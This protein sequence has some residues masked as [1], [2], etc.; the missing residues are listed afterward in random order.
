[1]ADQEELARDHE[2]RRSL[3]QGTSPDWTGDLDDDCIAYW[4]GF[5]LKAEWMNDDPDPLWFWA[6]SD[7]QTG[8]EVDSEHYHPDEQYHSGEEAR[9]AAEAA[10]RK[11]LGLITQIAF[12][13]RPDI[14]PRQPDPR[15]PT[16]PWPIPWRR[17]RVHK[18]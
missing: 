15:A 16:A 7:M 13:A 3:A 5:M 9:K 2:A 4:A 17:G 1:M 11:R 18:R 10:V 6:V 8:E 14:P 12:I